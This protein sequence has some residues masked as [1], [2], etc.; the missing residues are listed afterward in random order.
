MSDW[1]VVLKNNYEQLVGYLVAYV[2]QI[3]GALVLLLIGWLIA[4]LFGRLTLTLVSFTGKLLN[5]AGNALSLNKSVSIKPQHAKIISRTVFWLIMIFFFAAS[6][7]SLG[8]EFIATWLRE[9][10]GYLPNVLAGIVIVVGG[11]LIGNVA[12]TMAE[13]AASST[14]I[15]YSTRIGILTKWMIVGIAI[16]VGIEQLG[17]NIQFI[18]TLII[19]EVAIFSFGI[20]L[21]YGLGSKEL[22]K[23]L[24][25]SRQAGK[26]LHIGEYIQIGEYRGK[27]L[28]F[29]QTSLELE[30]EN[31][32]VL[33]P[34][35]I[36]NELPC[37]I[38]LLNETDNDEKIAS[39]KAPR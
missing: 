3:I 15:K 4:F 16:V 8:I 19:V 32:R 11:F 17:M 25:G 36:Y 18:T 29:L 2:P 38:L 14:G 27:V 1:E 24:V 31:G 5:R 39:Q 30:T 7:S 21:A 22:V 37:E 9:L 13:A 12:K 20:A 34:A 6:L 10:L 26:H 33:I 28:G 23:N 35:K